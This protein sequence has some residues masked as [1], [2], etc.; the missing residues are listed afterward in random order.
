MELRPIYTDDD[1]RAALKAIDE[2]WNAEPGTDDGDKLE[3]LAILVEHYERTRWP[4]DTSH[5]D[6]INLLN[7]L[8]TDGGHTQSELSDLLGSKSRAS[9]VLRRK[10]AL[11]LEMI[12][13]IS[14]AWKVPADLLIGQYRLE[15]A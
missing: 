3:L 5:I 9:E 14:S 1:H 12:R 10:R 6:P 2:L 11:T 4:T 8:I 15:A 7:Y 13:K